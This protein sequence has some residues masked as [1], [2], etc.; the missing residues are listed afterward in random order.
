M[1]DGKLLWNKAFLCILELLLKYLLSKLINHL[2]SEQ[3]VVPVV[4]ER[5]RTLLM[6]EKKN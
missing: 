3:C 2:T 1:M 5:E 6:I 4:T